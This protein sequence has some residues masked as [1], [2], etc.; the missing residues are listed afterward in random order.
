MPSSSPAEPRSCGVLAQAVEQAPRERPAVGDALGRRQV[1]ELAVEPV[2]G[3]EPLVLVEHLPRVVATAARRRRSARTSSLTIAWISAASAERVLDARLRVA[4]ADLDGPE[5]R[6]RAHVVPEVGVVLDHAAATMKSIC[7]CVVLPVA[8]ARRDPDARERAEDRRARRRAARS[9]RRARTASWRDS[10][11]STGMW[12]RMPLATWIALSGSSTPTW[13]CMPEDQLLAGDEAQRARSGRGSASRA[14]IRWSSHIANGCVPAEPI[15][16]PRFGGGLR[17]T[18]ARSARSWRA[19]LGACSRTGVG[20]DLEHRLHQLGL[21][22]AVVGASSSRVS[23]ALTRSSVS[24][25]DDHQ[26]L[27]DA[28]RVAR[29]GE[30]VLHRAERTRQ[31]R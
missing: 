15:V 25:V 16:S 27:L 23:I 29:P 3:G 1:D 19:G 18:C 12:T 28:E 7:C 8:V 10:A 5:V 26:L 24:R 31:P 17:M 11:S 14:T 2:A 30:A 22:L 6:V 21:D 4:H 9:R 13:T 20:R